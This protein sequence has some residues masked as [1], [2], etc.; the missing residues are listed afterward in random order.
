MNERDTL[1]RM[2][3]TGEID[4]R[5][6]IRSMSALGVSASAASLLL[7]EIGFAA[8]TPKKGGHLIIGLDGANTSDSLD[9]ATY[10]IHYMINVGMQLYNQLT[11]LDIK[12]VPQPSLA[13]SWDVK[14]GG[15]EWVFKIRKG[16]TFHNGKE[17][18]AADVVYSMEHH[19]GPDSKSPAKPLMA[20]MSTI[21]ATDKY[22]VTFTLDSANAE[23]HYLLSDYHL[24]I[25]PDGSN[26]LDGIGTGAL[27]HISLHPGERKNNKRKKN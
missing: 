17:L 16:V 27:N 10:T 22:E 26:F 8:E 1:H 15:K 25:G 21:K 20:S 18:T 9:P 6:F 19:H 13:E 11:E 7:P 5:Q 12:G 2:L 3:L 14:S 24:S 4:R 23:I